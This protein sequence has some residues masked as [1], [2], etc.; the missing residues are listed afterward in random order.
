VTTGRLILAV[1][2]VL[3]LLARKKRLPLPEGAQREL[4]RDH[5]LSNYQGGHAPAD[6]PHIADDGKP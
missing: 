4:A 3:A 2:A 6:A 5:D 1:G